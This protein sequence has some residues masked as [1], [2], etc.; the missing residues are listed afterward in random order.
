MQK[1]LAKARDTVVGVLVEAEGPGHDLDRDL[2]LADVDL[3]L[4]RPVGYVTGGVYRLRRPSFFLHL[5]A[6]PPQVG[7]KSTITYGRHLENKLVAAAVLFHT[8]TAKL[9]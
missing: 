6:D 7:G 9:R 4:R 3:L 8:E 5:S 2:F 1:I